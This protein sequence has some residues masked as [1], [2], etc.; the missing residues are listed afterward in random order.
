MRIKRPDHPLAVALCLTCCLFAPLLAGAADDNPLDA[1]H[2][3]DTQKQF[4]AGKVSKMDTKGDGRV[5]K[6]GFT[7]YYSDLWDKNVPTGKSSVSTRELSDKWAAMESQ[8]PTDPEYKT[9]MWRDK[10][11]QTMDTDHDGTV[12]KDE[13]LTHMQGHWEEASKMAHASSLS[14]SEATDLLLNPLD[15]RYHKN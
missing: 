12:S 8:N 14:H 4:W 1:T 2:M 10:H 6:E 15:P 13:F 5:T 7:K 9:D 11:V 3:S